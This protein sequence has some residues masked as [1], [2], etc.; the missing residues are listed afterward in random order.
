MKES[1]EPA[2]ANLL[3]KIMVVL[4]DTKVYVDQQNEELGEKIDITEMEL[5]KMKKLISFLEEQEAEL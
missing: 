3:E 2:V 4:E 5:R 1:G